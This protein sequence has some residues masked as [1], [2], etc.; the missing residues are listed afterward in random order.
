MLFS[1]TGQARG[2]KG[3][4]FKSEEARYTLS[5]SQIGFLMKTPP[6]TTL[7]VLAL[8]LGGCSLLHQKTGAVAR[9][10]ETDTIFP[11]LKPQQVYFFLSPDAFPLDL[12][13]VPV[14]EILTPWNSQWTYQDL[15]LQFQA[16][17]AEVGAN[18]IVF[19]HVGKSKLDMGYLAYDGHATAYRLYRDTSSQTVDLSSY[20][21]GTQNPDLSKV[22]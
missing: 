22:K 3:F 10:I 4:T 20:Q 8:A 2:F 6:L 11:P 17:A 7:L 19:D 12:H 16:K 13:S 1:T 9:P 18:A 5:K 14:A 15:L 21:Y